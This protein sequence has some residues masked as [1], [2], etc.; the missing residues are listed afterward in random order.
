MSDQPYSLGEKLASLAKTVT[1]T[2]QSGQIAASAEVVKVR[3]ATCDV[4]PTNRRRGRVCTRCTCNIYMK[5]L[6]AGS[7]CPDGHWKPSTKEN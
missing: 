6:L 7:E 3:R 1:N 5:T 2:V 4:C